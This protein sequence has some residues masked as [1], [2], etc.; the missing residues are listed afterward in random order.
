MDYP[1]DFNKKRPGPWDDEPNVSD[2]RIDECK[3][4]VPVKWTI[5]TDRYRTLGR[6]EAETEEDARKM[7]LEKHNEYTDEDIKYC[8]PS[9]R[10]NYSTTGY[11]IFSLMGYY[12][13]SG[14]IEIYD[15]K[16]DSGYAISEGSYWVPLEDENKVRDFFND[17]ET[18]KPMEIKVG[19]FEECQRAVADEVGVPVDKLNDREEVKKFADKKY[20]DYLDS[21]TDE[22]KKHLE[23][24]YGE[25]KWNSIKE[26]V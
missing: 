6:I 14:R 16:D 12:Y 4:Y 22:E 7:F 20:Q 15:E 9:G 3:T 8:R 23:E 18:S 21:L 19:H 13:A 1:T 25:I 10:Y 2:I 17:L 11:G 5:S 26:S 24:K